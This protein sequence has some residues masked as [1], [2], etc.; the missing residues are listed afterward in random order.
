MRKKRVL[1]SVLVIALLLFPVFRSVGAGN[2]NSVSGE[3]SSENWWSSHPRWTQ[4]LASSLGGMVGSAVGTT[5]FSL[6]SYPVFSGQEG[7]RNPGPSSLYV[8]FILGYP[9]GSALGAGFGVEKSAELLGRDGNVLETY[10]T[11]GLTAAGTFYGSLA[12]NAGL[13]KLTND[14]STKQTI[15]IATGSLAL[16]TPLVSSTVASWRYESSSFQNNSGL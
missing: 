6:L 4:W 3:N 11:S 2:E 7:I 14:P 15:N 16:A 13:K 1:I 10:L 9:T 8:G 5:V 12:L